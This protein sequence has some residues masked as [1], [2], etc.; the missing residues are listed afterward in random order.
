[1]NTT[2]ISDILIALFPFIVALVVYLY[3]LAVQRLPESQVAR[4]QQ[5]ALMTV[6]YI[7]QFYSSSTGAQKKELAMQ[8]LIQ[9]FKEFGLPVPDEAVLN[10]AIE[11]AVW[12][13]KQVPTTAAK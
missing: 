6:Q 5:F 9:L 7:Q 12:I 1:M 8:M 2:P 13:I 3:R 11:A 10:A 4:L